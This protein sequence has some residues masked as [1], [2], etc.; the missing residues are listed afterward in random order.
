MIEKVAVSQAVRAAFPDDYQGLYTAEEF[1][2]TDRD[3]EK[4]QVIDTGAT[5]N[6]TPEVYEE[7]EYISQEQRQEF[8]DLATGF[9][10]KKKGN[11]VVKYICTNMG[12][13]STTNMT[14]VQFEEAMATLKNGIEADKKNT[15]QETEE[16][17]AEA[18]NE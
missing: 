12:L 14:V 5:G 16:Q 13:E 8:F 6:A 2:Y 4:G 15:A 1:G 9:Y 7:V 17:S 3:A 18:G 10:G 11:A